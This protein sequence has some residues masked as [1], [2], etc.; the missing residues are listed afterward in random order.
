MDLMSTAEEQVSTDLKVETDKMV[1]VI[2][3]FLD[4]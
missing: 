1:T 4:K 3:T 2:N